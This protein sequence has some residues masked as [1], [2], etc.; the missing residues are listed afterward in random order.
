MLR[1]F[2]LPVLSRAH[3]FPAFGAAIRCISATP[4]VRAARDPPGNDTWL[5]DDDD[6]FWFLDELGEFSGDTTDFIPPNEAA[7]LEGEYPSSVNGRSK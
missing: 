4:I 6:D 2:A 1:R 7:L 5:P 3:W